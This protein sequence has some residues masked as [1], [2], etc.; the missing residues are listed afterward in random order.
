MPTTRPAPFSSEFLAQL[1]RLALL[2]RRVFRGRVRGE[3]RS[4]RR[5]HSVEFCDYRAY[6]VGDDLRYVD[7]NI[8]GRLDRLHVKLFVD[9]EDL[10]LHLLLDASASMDFG[11][12]TKLEYGARLAAALGFVGLVG[13]ERVG[14]GVLRERVAEGWSPTR[15]RNQVV[16]LFEFLGRVG[17]AGGTS[18]NDGL[19]NYAMRAREPGLAVVVSDLMDPAGFETGVRALLERRFDVHLVHVLA[20]EEMDPELAGDLRLVDAETGETRE[21]SVDGEALRTY[22]ERLR[23]FLERVETFSR[24]QEIGYHRV[25]TDTPVEEFVLAQ[26]RG[27]LLV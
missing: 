8:Y 6:G 5:G 23:Q 19:G 16:N 3:R 17:P 26:I 18:L 14:V 13:M 12:P 7:W 20:P 1:E 4:P 9:E 24:T 27:R 15:G 10:C 11:A 2:S 22:R 25:T 21:L